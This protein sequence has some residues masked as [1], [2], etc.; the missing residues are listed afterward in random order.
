[1]L[2]IKLGTVEAV[3]LLQLAAGGG[4]AG[5]DGRVKVPSLSEKS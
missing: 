4:G 2:A 3:G 5:G 1:M